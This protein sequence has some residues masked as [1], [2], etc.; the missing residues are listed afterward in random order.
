MNLG[1]RLN[2]STI[3]TTNGG[4]IR[5]QNQNLEALILALSKEHGL[6]PADT[7]ALAP[8]FDLAALVVSLRVKQYKDGTFAIPAT[9]TAGDLYIALM[10]ARK[11]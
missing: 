9:T 10:D 7:V 8:E 2:T 11:Y 4:P 6:L 1:T 5:E 3:V